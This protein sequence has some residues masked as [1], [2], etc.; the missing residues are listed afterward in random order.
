MAINLLW[1]V[2]RDVEQEEDKEGDGDSMCN[3]EEIKCLE[4]TLEEWIRNHL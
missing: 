4:D 3:A 1:L 2:M